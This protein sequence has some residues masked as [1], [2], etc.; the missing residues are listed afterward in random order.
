MSPIEYFFNYSHFSIIIIIVFE[1]ASVHL[2]ICCSTVLL[3]QSLQMEKAMFSCCFYYNHSKTQKINSL[4]SK[5]VAMYIT[6]SYFIECSL[7][8]QRVTL[9]L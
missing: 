6:G 1:I 7:K 3:T 4:D 2:A 8:N 9:N 5:Y